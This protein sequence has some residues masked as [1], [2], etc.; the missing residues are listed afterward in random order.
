MAKALFGHVVSPGD[1]QSQ[2]EVLQLR[3]Q[4][5]RLKAELALLRAENERLTSLAT[6]M[7]E[8]SPLLPELV[9]VSDEALT[10]V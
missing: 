3:A 1:A 8:P 9:E 5:A 6:E 2:Y 10:R 4:V 7:S